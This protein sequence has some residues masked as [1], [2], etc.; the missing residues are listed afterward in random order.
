MLTIL[1]AYVPDNFTT[2]CQRPHAGRARDGMLPTVEFHGVLAARPSLQPID[3][4]HKL[5]LASL[6]A[7]HDDIISL[8]GSSRCLD[9]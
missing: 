5:V 2:Y 3:C 6:Q 9:Q 7:D 8:F 4:E 1:N